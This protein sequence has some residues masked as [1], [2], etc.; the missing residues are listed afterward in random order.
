MKRFKKI[1]MLL[2]M[3]VFFTA[4]A[5]SVGAEGEEEST[6]VV[7]DTVTTEESEENV[8]S[9][10][11]EFA[12]GNYEQIIASLSLGLGGVLLV[13]MKKRVGVLVSG[14]V[15]MISGQTDATASAQ[16]AE[17]SAEAMREVQERLENKIAEIESASVERDNIS[18]ALLYEVMTLVQMQHT[19]ALNNANIPQAIKNYTTTLCANCLSAIENSEELKKAYDEMR[20]ILG[21]KVEEAQKDETEASS[22][23]G[24][25]S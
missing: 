2:L 19:L 10:L 7:E 17:K 23:G 13:Y 1:M 9:R 11:Y 4:S 21:I 22:C 12:T 25:L 24:T 8:F 15:K 18:K 14:I 6:P 16:N 5:V 20:G 3:A